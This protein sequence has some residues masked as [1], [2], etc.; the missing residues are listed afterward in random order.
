M[1]VEE[2]ARAHILETFLVTEE[3]AWRRAVNVCA[4]LVEKLGDL[5]D[6]P[7]SAIRR[8]IDL[9]LGHELPWRDPDHRDAFMAELKA[10]LDEARSRG[11]LR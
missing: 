5:T 6:L 1:T 2:I 8:N 4:F 10:E 9:T 3:E 11:L 7:P